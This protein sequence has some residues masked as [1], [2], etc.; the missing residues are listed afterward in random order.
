MLKRI[1]RLPVGVHR[2]TPYRSILFHFKRE[3]KNF[4]TILDVHPSSNQKE[5]KFAYYKMAKMYHPDF[6]GPNTSEKDKEEASEMFKKIQQAYE[7]LSNPIMRQAYDIE[8]SL[9]DGSDGSGPVDQS[10]YED[11]TSNRSYY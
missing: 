4:Y 8:H 11:Q 1:C 9:N 2:M 7:T 6:Q 5:I 10:I 3:E